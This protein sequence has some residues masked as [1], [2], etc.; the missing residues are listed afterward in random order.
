MEILKEAPHH[1][2]QGLSRKYFG[3]KKAL[4]SFFFLDLYENTRFWSAVSSPTEAF[5][6][7]QELY[8]SVFALISKKSKKNFDVLNKHLA[9]I[10]TV[11]LFM[12]MDPASVQDKEWQ[13]TFSQSI[14]SH[15]DSYLTS[16]KNA[17]RLISHILQFSYVLMKSTAKEEF[18]KPIIRPLLSAITFTYDIPI[19]ETNYVENLEI[20]LLTNQSSFDI[21]EHFIES[22]APLSKEAMAHI[23]DL[24]ETGEFCFAFEGFKEILLQS[25]I[26]NETFVDTITEKAKFLRVY[27]KHCPYEAYKGALACFHVIKTMLVFCPIANLESLR[28]IIEEFEMFRRWP[29]P[30]GVVANE[31]ID[32]LFENMRSPFASYIFQTRENIPAVDFFNID[33]QHRQISLKLHCLF[34]YNPIVQRIIIQNQ[35]RHK[36][37]DQLNANSLRT[38]VVLSIFRATCKDIDDKFVREFCSLEPITIFKMYCCAMSII[39]KIEDLVSVKDARELLG[40]RLESLKN[41]IKEQYSKVQGNKPNQEV[42]DFTKKNLKWLPSVFH[43][44]FDPWN[45]P[46][47]NSIGFMESQESEGNLDTRLKDVL[48]EQKRL[49][50]P[51]HRKPI[52]LLVYGSQKELSRFVNALGKVYRMDSKLLINADFRFFYIPTHECNIASFLAQ[53][54]FWYQRHIYVPFLYPTLEPMVRRPEGPGNEEGKKETSYKEVGQL[55]QN[56]VHQLPFVLQERLIQSFCFDAQNVLNVRVY[57]LECWERYEKDSKPNLTRY[58]FNYLTMGLKNPSRKDKKK[59]VIK[60]INI[61]T[62]SVEMNGDIPEDDTI[63]YSENTT[64][65]V[66]LGLY[67]FPSADPNYLGPDPSPNSNW[68]EL[69]YLDEEGYKQEHKLLKDEKNLKKFQEQEIKVAVSALYTNL[70]VHTCEISSKTSS[71]EMEVDGVPIPPYSHA[72]ITPVWGSENKSHF[73]TVPFMTFVPLNI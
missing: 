54:D 16:N 25:K 66:S 43:Y 62:F 11:A 30:V 1:D 44:E 72:R 52:N 47:G 67:N 24:E 48:Q 18:D 6:Y 55:E 33:N 21:F 22:I 14:K 69:V 53:N 45:Q 65:M 23:N 59:I 64:N 70:H 41:D 8:K 29:F 4:E 27:Q 12:K 63:G 15:L 10:Y 7:M 50:L 49:D 51:L 26:N 57:Q 61:K 3:D 38:L 39:D 37:F 40:K 35:N 34:D 20:Y 31:V 42:I 32:L 19:P 46:L 58:F 28:R 13:A 73:L 68:M 71:F 60:D 36:T 5:V 56:A 17:H 9:T 2:V